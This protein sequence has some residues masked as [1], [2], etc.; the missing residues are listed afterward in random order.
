M[1]L[2]LQRTDFEYAATQ[3]GITDL[4]QA[5]EDYT[6]PHTQAAYAVW[7]SV[8]FPLGASATPPLAWLNIRGGKAVGIS[9]T[10]PTGP[11]SP[12]WAKRRAQGWQPSMPMYA[13]V[14]GVGPEVQQVIRE[15]Q[16]Q[17]QEEGYSI[18][19]DV[20]QYRSGELPKA[21]ACYAMQA[22]GVYPMRYTSFWPFKSKIKSCQPAE[23]LTKA[24]ALIL[25]EIERSKAQS[26]R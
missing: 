20:E 15:L 16:R 23:A 6:N 12:D 11:E 7:K 4:E 10:R 25:A 5:G 19:S 1:A 8:A 17:R 24:V 13:N 3:A 22:A 26:T 18:E 14:P 9:M 2:F 21:A